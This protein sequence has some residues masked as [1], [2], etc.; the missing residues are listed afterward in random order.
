MARTDGYS[1]YVCD[2]CNATT[3]A[4]PTSLE[5]HEWHQI[6]RVSASERE[7]SGLLCPG[8]HEL[9]T[10]LVESQDLAFG[11][12]MQPPASNEQEDE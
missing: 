3:Y 8:C 11:E 7:V 10:E 12:F 5:A 9:Y 1:Q 2:R 6:R 4:R